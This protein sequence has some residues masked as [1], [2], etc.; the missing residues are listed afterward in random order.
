MRLE[1]EWDFVEFGHIFLENPPPKRKANGKSLIMRTMII[2][3]TT[4]DTAETRANSLLWFWGFNS[5]LNI[6]KEF[7]EYERSQ[8]F[9]KAIYHLN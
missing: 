1:V 9:I 8:Q 3:N 4:S 6:S 7:G 5:V 2:M